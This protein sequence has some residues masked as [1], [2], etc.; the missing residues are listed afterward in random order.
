LNVRIALISASI[1]ALV[2]SVGC[3]PAS[4]TELRNPDAFASNCVATM[5]QRITRSASIIGY[6]IGPIIV[7]LGDLDDFMQNNVE[8]LQQVREVTRALRPEVAELEEMKRKLFLSGRLERR[9]AHVTMQLSTGEAIKVECTIYVPASIPDSQIRMEEMR[10]NGL[11][12]LDW[13]AVSLAS[14]RGLF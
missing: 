9:S 10:A 6:E 13:N 8:V 1:L 12:A 5:Q 2:F 3:F 7:S 4:S 14:S 11:T